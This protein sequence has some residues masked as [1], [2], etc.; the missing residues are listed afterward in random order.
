MPY[1]RL[2]RTADADGNETDEYMDLTWEDVKSYR[3]NMFYVIDQYQ[4]VL[5]YNSLTETQKTEL[6]TLR[7]TLLD[8]PSDYETANE[9]ADNCPDFP[10]WMIG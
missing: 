4:I 9:A 2:V 5:R 3:A 1:S 7:Q 8:L 6:A 10:D